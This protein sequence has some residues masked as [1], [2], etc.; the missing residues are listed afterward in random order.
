M[1]SHLDLFAVG[2]SGTVYMTSYDDSGRWAGHWFPLGDPSFADGFTLSL[3]T[4]IAA[5]SRGP[6]HPDLFAVGK[7][8]AV[9]MTSYD[10]L[11]VAVAAGTWSV[12]SGTL[13]TT[14]ALP[15]SGNAQ[16]TLNKTGDTMFACHAH[17]AGADDI[18]Y[19]IACVYLTADATAAFGYSH[20]GHLHGTASGIFG[21]SRDDDFGP[22]S[23]IP[24]S[25][26]TGTRYLAAHGNAASLAPTHYS[27]E[28]RECC[29]N[30]SIPPCKRQAQNSGK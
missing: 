29:G 11:I 19:T 13:T 4:P 14:G 27:Q 5:I 23:P 6:S 15:L 28:W 24:L 25:Q 3:N 16:L 17:D 1:P 12:D 22:T 10:D 8:G 18:D 21:G 2:K 30:Y 20:Q 26:P 7:D 9:Y